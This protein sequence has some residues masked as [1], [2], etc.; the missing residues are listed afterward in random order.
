MGA[1]P[2]LAHLVAVRSAQLAQL[3][4]MLEAERAVLAS[5]AV[6]ERRLGRA[7]DRIGAGRGS[8]ASRRTR[9]VV[10]AENSS[11]GRRSTGISPMRRSSSGSSRSV[12]KIAAVS[13]HEDGA[14][15]A[16]HARAR[17]SAC[18]TTV[19]GSISSR[20]DDIWR[21]SSSTAAARSG[22]R[23]SARAGHGATVHYTLAMASTVAFG[24]QPRAPEVARVAAAPAV[25]GIAGQLRAAGGLARLAARHRRGVQQPE[26]ITE[27][28][29]ADRQMRDDPR[30][31]RRQSPQ[32]LVVARLLGQV[33][34]QMP[35]PP[36]GQREELAVVGAC[37][38]TSAR[39]P[40][41]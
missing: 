11:G 15:A 41:R 25:G 8:G 6:C 22:P 27:R 17:A 10:A 9:K 33:R 34:E 5:E 12:A 29:G 7:R 3:V 1:A 13:P 14:D 19:A 40:G 23:S 20:A 28:R 39:R 35:E 30:D 21:R 38:R 18:W 37:P 31:P 26:T 4:A 36:P 16:D 24:I 2:G 32:A